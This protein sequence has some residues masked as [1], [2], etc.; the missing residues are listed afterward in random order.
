MEYLGYN[1]DFLIEGIDLKLEPTSFSFSMYDSIH[2]IFP[3]LDIRIDDVSG[4]FQEYLMSTE[5]FLYSINYGIDNK[6]ISNKFVVIHDDLTEL[7]NK[8]YFSGKLNIKC[9]HEYYNYQEIK[10]ASYKNTISSIINQLS[11]SYNFTSK[12]IS[13][14]GC[15][16]FF[17]QP[18]LTDADFM[19]NILLPN[20]YSQNSNKSPFFLF[21]DNNNAF[22]LKTYDD[23][24][25]KSSVA[26]LNYINEKTEQPQQDTILDIKRIKSGSTIHKHLRYRDIL[27]Q[28]QTDGSIISVSDYNYQYPSNMVGKYMPIVQNNKKTGYEF[29]FNDY[30]N[31]ELGLKECYLGRQIN[32]MKDTFFIERLIITTPLNPVLTS[33][34]MVSIK[35]PS[36]LSAD[37]TT[38]SISWGGQWL[39]ESCEH[40]WNGVEKKGYTKIT[41]AKKFI[42]INQGTYNFKDKLTKS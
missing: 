7:I 2:N 29:Y 17:T 4:L 6:F 41:V 24:V 5:G 14:T 30:G 23:M 38:N 40:I 32:S 27:K 8:T 26:T 39:I 15:N 22:N 3:E 31:D 19:D 12:S 1:L 25:S 21:I 34:N 37:N 42:D 10:S 33:G 28:S 18:L 11:G 16:T 35:I 36:P 20:A 13:N 9:L